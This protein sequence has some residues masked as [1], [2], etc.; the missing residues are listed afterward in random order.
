VEL[1]TRR[2]PGQDHHPADALIVAAK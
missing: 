1:W 2:D